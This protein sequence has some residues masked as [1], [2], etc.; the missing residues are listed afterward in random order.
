MVEYSKGYLSRTRPISY[1]LAI[2]F[3]HLLCS[4]LFPKY[5]SGMYFGRI[6][7]KLTALLKL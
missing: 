4:K 5:I 3:I 7:K 1:S 6:E 2:V